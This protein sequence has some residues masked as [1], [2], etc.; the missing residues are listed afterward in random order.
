MKSENA[1]SDQFTEELMI[2]PNKEKI[3]LLSFKYDIEKTMLESVLD[4]YLSKHDFIYKLYK[5]TESKQEI[6]KE[7]Y[8]VNLNFQETL[9]ELSNKYNI[10]KSKLA[11]III[12]YKIWSAC[13]EKGNDTVLSFPSYE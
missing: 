9:D 12:D 6:I 13:E 8:E 5:K 7:D 1:K 11:N 4:E 10:P 2:S 3:A